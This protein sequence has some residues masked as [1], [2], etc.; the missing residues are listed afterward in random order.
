MSP[1]AGEGANLALQDGAMLGRALAEH[2]GD[3]EAAFAAY[4][5]DLFVRAEASA[6]D[7]AAGLA[8]CFNDEAPDS[9]V[10]FFNRLGARQVSKAA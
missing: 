5:A 6:T 8:M 9:L 10:D 2:G 4:E 7:S 1:F 3:V